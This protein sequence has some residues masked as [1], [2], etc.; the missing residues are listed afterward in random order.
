VVNTAPM[1]Y[2]LHFIFFVTLGR[3]QQA[4]VFVPYKPF[5]PSVMKQYSLFTSY[6]ENGVVNMV[7]G[8]YSK[9]FIFFVTFKRPNKLEHYI[10]L[11]WKG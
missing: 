9:H 6:E 2:Y 3:A 10:T 4:R 1:S 8:L 5:L 11:G 7:S